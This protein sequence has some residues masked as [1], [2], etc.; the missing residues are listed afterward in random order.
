METNIIKEEDS[1][2]EDSDLDKIVDEIN[3]SSNEENEPNININY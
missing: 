2:I 1:D 3:S